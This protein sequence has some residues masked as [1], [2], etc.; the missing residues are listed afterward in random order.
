MN[1][2]QLINTI[3]NYLNLEEARLETSV[4]AKAQFI[5]PKKVSKERLNKYAEA[6]QRLEDFEVFRRAIL[7][8]IKFY[9]D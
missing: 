7:D 3:Y 8:I 9:D 5:N 6:V 4:Y 2:T 1:I